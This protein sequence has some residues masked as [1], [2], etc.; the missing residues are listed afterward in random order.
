MKSALESHREEM[1]TDHSP[2]LKCSPASHCR[3]LVMALQSERAA[4]LQL[5]IRKAGNSLPFN[6]LPEWELISIAH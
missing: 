2:S 6:G 5:R 4:G 1:L 3:C